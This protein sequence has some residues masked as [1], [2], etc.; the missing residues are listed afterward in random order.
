MQKDSWVKSMHKSPLSRSEVLRQIETGQLS[1]MDALRL[2]KE[3]SADSASPAPREPD[4]SQL[5]YFRNEWSVS[6]ATPGK[7]QPPVGPILIFDDDRMHCHTFQAQLDKKNGTQ[8]RL[9]LVQPGEHYRRID[10]DNYEIDLESANDYRALFDDL[11]ANDAVPSTI[12]Y[13][14]T[15]TSPGLDLDQLETDLNKGLFSVL[16]CSKALFELRAKHQ[17][18]FLYFYRGDSENVQPQHAALSGFARSLRKEQPKLLFRTIAVDSNNARDLGGI[19][20]QEIFASDDEVE[21]SYRAGTRRVRRLQRIESFADGHQPVTFRERGVYLITGGVGGVGLKV[22]EHL[23]GQARA[24]LVLV[25]RSDL[26]AEQSKRIHKLAAA[27]A[28]VFYC[29]ADVSEHDD[30]QRLIDETKARFNALNG[31]IHCAGVTRDAFVLNKSRE[32]VAAVLA[33]KVLGTLWLDEVTREEPL[34]FFVLFSSVAASFGSIGQAD[35]AYANSFMDSFAEWRNALCGQGKRFGKSLAINWPLWQDGGM[36]V[37]PR[38]QALMREAG[39]EL[40]TTVDGLSA[41]RDSLGSLASQQIVLFGKVDSLL[42]LSNRHAAPVDVEARNALSDEARVSLV[43]K[44]EAYLKGILAREAKL[45]PSKI[46]A[47][48][49]LENLGIDS[50]LII[51]LTRELEKVFGELPKTLFFEYQTL[52]ELSEYFVERYGEKIQTLVGGSSTSSAKGS[53]RVEEKPAASRFNRLAE[54]QLPVPPAELTRAKDLSAAI[55][56]RAE[57]RDDIA[58]IGLAGRYPL[59]DDLTQLW[60]NLRTGR[61]CIT[62]IPPDRWDHSLIFNADKKRLG[63]SYSKWGGFIND[64]DKFDPVFFNISP[65][66]AELI[67]PQERLFL[68]TVWETI[69]DA[70]YTRAQLGQTRAGVFVGVM[71]GQY[72]LFSAENAPVNDGLVFGSSFAS[73]ANRT[74]YFFNFKG[75]SIALD[76]MCSSSLTAIH[77]ACR[78]IW[79]GD[80]A[81]AIAGGVNLT[82]H[83]QKY[84]LLSQGR[85][86]ASDGRCRS[87][88][89]GGDGYVPGEGVGAVLLKP[90]R[91]AVADKD[92]IYGVIKGT[93]INHGG[94]T[95]GYTVPNPK[96]QEELISE[97]LQ[98]A[99]I[100]AASIS[101][102][103][104]H[105]TGTS[106]GDPIE[107]AGLARAF[108][109]G[110][111][112]KGAP[113][114]AKSSCPIG[115]VKSN[116]GHL[117]SAA[118][119]AALTKVLLQFKHRQLVPSLHAKRI[120]PNLTLSETP[121]FVQQELA[122]WQQPL[123]LLNGAEQ[124]CPRRAGISGFGAGGANAHVV[125]EEYSDADSLAVEVDESPQIIVFS[126][127]NQE[128]LKDY[129]AR[130]LR[131]LNGGGEEGSPKSDDKTK[132]AVVEIQKDLLALAAA[133]VNVTK[134]EID[135]NESLVEYGF[136]WR[137]FT[138]LIEQ[139]SVRYKC[140]LEPVALSSEPSIVA[141]AHYVSEHAS[142]Q[143]GSTAT[144]AFEENLS[145]PLIRLA[146]LAYT[147][148]VGRE[149]MRERLAIVVST[150]HELRAS[151][152]HYLD[153]DPD[154]RMHSGSFMPGNSTPAGLVEGRAGKE[155]IKLLIDDAELDKLAQ[156]WVSGVEIDW[157]QL[158][159]Q[160]NHSER[161][162]RRISLP[163]YPFEKNRYWVPERLTVSPQ[164]TRLHPLIDRN[165]STLD[166]TSFVTQV[167]GNEPWFVTQGQKKILPALAL[168]EMVRAA[169]TLA[170]SKR[171]RTLKNI[172][173]GQPLAAAGDLLA[174]RVN[175]LANEGGVEYEVS[176]TSGERGPVV[177]SQGMLVYEDPFK[178]HTNKQENSF[179][180]LDLEAVK[181]RCSDP[182]SADEFYRSL[183][184]LGLKYG[185]EQRVVTEVRVG[186]D[187]A[188]SRF[189][190]AGENNEERASFFLHPL[191]LDGLLQVASIWLSPAKLVTP[192][193]LAEIE[194]YQSFPDD[195]SAYVQVVRNQSIDDFPEKE[196][197]VTF[198]DPAGQVL[199]KLAGLIVRYQERHSQAIP[200]L[201]RAQATSLSSKSLR[202]QLEADLQRLAAALIK[203][204]PEQLEVTAGLGDFG[205]ESVTFVE[206]AERITE[207]FGVEVAP[208]VF[209][210]SDNLRGLS[211]YLI[212]EFG[213]QLQAFYVSQNAADVVSE[214]PVLRADLSDQPVLVPFAQRQSDKHRRSH[215]R[216]SSSR[217][218]SQDDIAVIGMSGV[219]PGSP[220]LD[221]FWE[222]LRDEKDLI[223]EIPADRWNWRDY[224]ADFSTGDFKTQAKWGGFIEDADKFDARFFS[225]SPLEAEMMD[226]QQ[227]V[228]LETVWKAIEDAGYRASEFAGRQVG[229][230][231]GVQFSDY[232]QMLASQGLLNAQMGLGNEHS[233]LVNRIS[234]LLNLRGP[235]EPYNTA[236][237]S[238]LVAVHRA[239]N[240][241]RSGES[242]LAI[243]GGISLMLSPYTTISGDSLGVLSVDGR[244]KTLDSSA[245]GYVRGE[246]A[247]A[248]L[249]KP[250]DRALLDNDNIYA[251]IKGT[252]VNHGG[253]ASSLTAPNSEAQAALLVQAYREANF[254]PESVSYL[255]L[256]GTGTKLGDPIEIEGIKRAFKQL[257]GSRPKEQRRTQYCGI[258]SVKTNIGHLEPASGIAGI[259][260]L[261]LSMK[262]RTLPGLLHLKEL[263]PYVKLENT[264]FFIVD[265]TQPWEQLRDAQQQLLPRRAGVSSFG[266][267]G[268]NAHVVLQEYEA[269]AGTPDTD[270]QLI[271]LSAKNEERLR[272]YADKLCHFR[273]NHKTPRRMSWLISPTRCRLAVR[274]LMNASRSSFQ[275]RQN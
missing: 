7:T 139:I 249:L 275:T 2:I 207:R 65:A 141:L 206:L 180:V 248:L 220:D 242:E 38:A 119:I 143:P 262:H 138:K 183:A 136:D 118:G 222:N 225:I 145:E 120:N 48:E 149:P 94:K 130:Y 135:L 109:K 191:L 179:E 52:S 14:W 97:A 56:D 234:Y 239:V 8:H 167:S 224:H 93:A 49:P 78:S 69:E 43:P 203:I 268:V 148:Q 18:E 45:A 102:I 53:N 261:I 216:G 187:E 111:D 241:I 11:R 168:M 193:R 50:L 219:F 127:R 58:I 157:L 36:T 27:G 126:A 107:I 95:N 32:E 164:L 227:R 33:P 151:L 131:L 29:R 259:M 82:I 44:A 92:H 99:R 16:L 240:S 76:T 215:R 42:R 201:A 6:E 170:E 229:L 152:Q 79:Q 273:Q 23:A 205:F 159:Q 67:D 83:P 185:D 272:A 39:V 237:S 61:D 238:A 196:L 155:F 66:E 91:Q 181:S 122:E 37:D 218:Q 123:V 217:D 260:K 189:V 86:A 68:E 255:E 106:L 198:V 247:G 213:E 137:N 104:A 209:F 146:D 115:S 4:S 15:T 114:V 110:V 192:L 62:E 85:F 89:E 202:Q 158:H 251:V 26:T 199:A 10:G 5:V 129:V 134:D 221:K 13:L 21:I 178:G 270:A 188:L 161:L 252:A 108:G 232:Q 174:L 30:V 210:E 47:H 128:R 72:Q 212:N 246:G 160:T 266:F 24:R 73:I 22:A 236:C 28:E 257:A 113:R 40:L 254:D 233:I 186:T 231:V 133:Q 17:I 84:Q 173:F 153:G 271:V 226:P 162:P 256:H 169:A 264:P 125:V 121:F 244:C 250:L 116:I 243:A 3:L 165:V 177:H 204:A 87:F 150:Q 71:Y 208:T 223:S 54:S 90:L 60:E 31:I 57:Q 156:L 98:N 59:A 175:L 101:Y 112:S 142:P 55:V 80:C 124:A 171:V 70:G 190:L 9:I 211:A 140:G 20:N 200:K 74:S 163:T 267:G 166:Q 75:P 274:N 81:L 100:D 19:I 51:T 88:G 117:E 172:R 64:V 184:S 63:K 144:Q 230:F 35:Y 34:D 228:F 25:G 77:L 194:L 147:L 258:G 263:N 214:L 195:V 265:R 96:A 245:N 41:F 132:E 253:K 12:V 269:A 182:T 197:T 1:S 154:D 235:S 46:Q 105:G 176:S 103:E